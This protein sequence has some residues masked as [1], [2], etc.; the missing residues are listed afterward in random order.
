VASGTYSRIGELAAA[1]SRQLREYGTD[2]TTITRDSAG[3]HTITDGASQFTI[4][5]RDFHV[6]SFRSNVVMRWEWTPGSTVFVVWQQNRRSDLLFGDPART[7][8]LLRT[9]RVAG[10][11][12][13][14]VKFT[15]WL[16]VRFG[17]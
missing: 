6:L 4:S 14:S 17:R 8:E 7:S 16:P 3:T 11:N 9:T 15:Y 12:F 13:L 2:G 10:D 1:R 5:N